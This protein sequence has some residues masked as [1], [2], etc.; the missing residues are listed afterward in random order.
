M[1]S[2]KTSVCEF[3]L[4]EYSNITSPLLCAFGVICSAVFALW[5][6]LAICFIFLIL[7][8]RARHLNITLSNSKLTVTETT[9]LFGLS[10]AEKIQAFKSKR[11]EVNR[12]KESV[13]SGS[14][15]RLAW[16]LSLNEKGVGAQCIVGM[17]N[18]EDPIIR[19]ESALRKFIQSLPVSAT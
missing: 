14:T 5:V 13:L 9:T 1:Y 16:V 10:L 17:F 8:L 4:I 3:S 11:V 2:C 19:I 12:V 7:S 18:N 15:Y 6:L